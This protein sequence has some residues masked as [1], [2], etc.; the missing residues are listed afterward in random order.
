MKMKFILFA[1]CGIL[2]SMKL[3]AQQDYFVFIHQPEGQ[4]FYVRMQEDSYSS[5][6]TGH[7]ILGSLK[8]STY[9]M[10]VGFPRSRYAEQLFIVKINKRDHGY[11]LKSE[12]GRWQLKAL[13]GSETITSANKSQDTALVRKTD[14]YSELM[15]GLV[16]DSTVLYKYKDTTADKAVAMVDS[17]VSAA[18]GGG[19]RVNQEGVAADT[20]AAAPRRKGKGKGRQQVSP[21]Q[22]DKIK[23]A[24]DSD[25]AAAGKQDV[26]LQSDSA[27]KQP[28]VIRSDSSVVVNVDSVA[29]KQAD[30]VTG[31]A[32]AE[33]TAGRRDPRDIIRFST[34]NVEA[35]KLIIYLD[36][37]G[38][39]VDTIRII[40]PR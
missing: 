12:G 40:I 5:S 13:Q 14:T 38:P 36:R 6:A 10:Y 34:E 39:V 21:A 9:N 24:L 37:T 15:A 32:N 7:I 17:T 18:E 29:G 26:A 31:A 23:P 33:Q 22:K 8:D 25:T 2:L 20:V 28:D 19:V 16:D 3:H 35:G 4:P 27:V 1:F 11:E 30:S